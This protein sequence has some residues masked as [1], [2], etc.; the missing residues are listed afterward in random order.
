MGGVLGQLGAFVGV[1]IDEM[2]HTALEMSQKYMFYAMKS[3]KTMKMKCP[4]KPPPE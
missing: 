1:Q 2:I 3:L 4:L